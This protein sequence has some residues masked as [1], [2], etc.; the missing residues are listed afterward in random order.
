MTTTHKNYYPLIKGRKKSIIIKHDEIKAY[1]YE[2]YFPQ[3]VWAHSVTKSFIITLGNLA[4]G[5]TIFKGAT[6][7]WKKDEEEINIYRLILDGREFGRTKLNSSL[8]KEI[9]K[10]MAEWAEW[11]ESK[12]EAFLFTETELS[13]SL[14]K[15]KDSIEQAFVQAHGAE[16]PVFK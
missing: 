2:F 10:L 16:Q 5:A 9:G 14:S 6:G 11:T 12:Q 8:H 1:Q 3:S 13:M 7:V 15:I 4:R